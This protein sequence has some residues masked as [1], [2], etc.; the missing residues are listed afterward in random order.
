MWNGASRSQSFGQESQIFI[1][2]VQKWPGTARI[3]AGNNGG[4]F[5][6]YR[7]ARAALNSVPEL[8][9]RVPVALNSSPISTKVS[10]TE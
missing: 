7:L 1:I 6:G 2:F 3:Q 4:H 5:A 9:S 10:R 8:L